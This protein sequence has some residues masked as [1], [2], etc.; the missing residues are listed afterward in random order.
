[1]TLVGPG[2]RGED[3]PRCRGRACARRDGFPDG[4]HFVDLIRD[5]PILRWFLTSWPPALGV[6]GESGRRLISA[7]VRNTCGTGGAW[8]LLDNCEHLL[9]PIATIAAQ[10]SGGEDPQLPAGNQPRAPGSDPRESCNASS[11]SRMPPLQTDSYKR[12]RSAEAYPSVELFTLRALET[13]DYQLVDNDALIVVAS[14]CKALDGLPLAIELAA[15]KL[16]QFSPTEL[17]N[18]VAHHL[19]KFRNY[20]DVSHPRHQTLWAMLDWSYQLLSTQEA[21]LFRLLSVFAGSFKWPDVASMAQ[22]VQYDPYQTTAALGGLISKSLLSAEIDGDQLSYR[23]LETV[24]CYATERLAKDPVTNDAH[25]LHAQIVLSLFEK[26]EKEWAWSDNRIWR[27]RYEV[28]TGDLRKALD[29][30]FAEG[31]D[32]SIGVDLTISAIRLWNEQSS[33]HEQLSQV[34]RA[35]SRCLSMPNTARRQATLANAR[36]WCIVFTQQPSADASEAYSTALNFA[37]RS[38]DIGERLSAMFRQAHFFIRTGRNEQAISLLDDVIRIATQAGDRAFLFDGE[39]LRAWAELHLGKLRDVQ[40]KLERL[41]KELADGVPPSRIL[42]YQSQ[43]YVGISSM[44]A[45]TTWLTGRPECALAMVEEMVLKTGAAG[46]L[47]GQSLILAHAAMPVAFLSGHIDSLIR[48]SNILRGN[49]DRENLALWVS[50]HRFYASFIQHSQRNPHAVDEMQSILHE[51]VRGGIVMRTPM[52]F[53][54]LADALLAGGRLADADE[55]V[56]FAL[57]L[58]RQAQENWCLPE[59][60]RVKAKIVAALGK[61]SHAGAIL[62]RA[63]ENAI[64]IGA[65]TLELRIVNDMAE[66]S[67]T[68]GTFERAVQLLKPLYETFEDGTATDDLKR[69][70]RLLAEA[71]AIQDTAHRYGAPAI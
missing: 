22:L 66:T 68:E 27:T 37:E 64:M 49:L 52:Y 45:F 28:R 33:L 62:A 47:M 58:H 41:A 67:I 32:A 10:L 29:W 54:V 34:D 36:A 9:H 23:Y 56:Q 59:L 57:M 6:R 46:Q 51:L 15:A 39:R 63:R 70:A 69:S 11:L 40:A 50:T 43:R 4:V 35:L 5:R 1:V 26:S 65:R 60:L 38:C 20:N 44:R 3:E 71:H 17:L 61:P 30:C 53:G 13:A 2:G 21:A 18:S 48:Y 24:R 16:D 12:T 55:A 25:R 31:G 42:R 19:S 7:L 8:L 14:L